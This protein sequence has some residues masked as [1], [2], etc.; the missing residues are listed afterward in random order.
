L[1]PG[2]PLLPGKKIQ[3]PPQHGTRPSLVVV[4]L[5][6]VVVS[7]TVLGVLVARRWNPQSTQ[8]AI[9]YEV[10]GSATKANVIYMTPDGQRDAIVALPWSVSFR[11]S[12]GMALSLVSRAGPSGSITCWIYEDGST[13]DT[14]T[15]GVGCSLGTRS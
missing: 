1:L 2:T 13:I 14:T 3:T 15:P 4:A 6:V 9:R 5:T 12:Q 8:H 7:T 10:T 11:T